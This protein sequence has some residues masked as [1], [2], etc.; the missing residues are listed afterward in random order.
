MQDGMP[1]KMQDGRPHKMQDGM[2]QQQQL[3]KV[4]NRT[5]ATMPATPTITTTSG[6]TC[7]NSYVCAWGTELYKC[8]LTLF[9]VSASY[10]NQGWCRNSCLFI[11]CSSA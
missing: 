10:H 1:H 3:I 2:L 9:L 6:S 7:I 5:S 11:M 8:T 4:H